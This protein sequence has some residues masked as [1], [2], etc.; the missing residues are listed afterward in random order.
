MSVMDTSQLKDMHLLLTIP[1]KTQFCGRYSS[2]NIHPTQDVVV[3]VYDGSYT[4]Q[5][6][7]CSVGTLNRDSGETIWG[8]V[9]RYDSGSHPSVALICMG[10]NLY[11]VEAHA[12]GFLNSKCCYRVGKVNR[13]Q[14]NI[15]WGNTNELCSG[16]KP[17]ICAN[18]DGTVVIV[19]EEKHAI[20][21][22]KIYHD[23]LKINLDEKTL[24]RSDGRE[25][26]VLDFEG[27][28]PNV[29]MSEEKVVLVYRSGV[30]ALK[31][32][33]GELRRDQTRIEWNSAISSTLPFAGKE[34]SVG[35]NSHGNIVESHQTALTMYR[36]I[37]YNYGHIS[38]DV[39]VWKSNEAH[40]VGE[41]PAIAIAN[42]GC[43]VEM[44]KTNFGANLYQSQGDLKNQVL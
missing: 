25:C 31:I 43:T 34:P 2:V 11:A 23:M 1:S 4:D 41:Y 40:T 17:K 38:N 6:L 39:I 8:P 44:H 13:A 10:N 14:K 29:A 19:H 26:E 30:S 35:L 12:S 32:A 36:L 21:G 9:S 5:Q 20:W 16:K 24:E 42:D 7:Y 37:S 18:D 27:V 15:E 3:C 28:E 22:E 33:V